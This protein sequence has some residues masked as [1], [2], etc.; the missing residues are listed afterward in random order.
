MDMMVSRAV[1]RRIIGFANR[2]ELVDRRELLKALAMEMVAM[3]STAMERMD[4]MKGIVG[5]SARIDRR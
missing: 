3:A 5:D 1:E 4:F 2:T